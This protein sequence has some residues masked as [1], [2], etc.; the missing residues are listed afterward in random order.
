MDEQ[1]IA[2]KLKANLPQPT[3]QPVA[4]TEPELNTDQATLKVD[5]P[6][7]PMVG[8]KLA[9]IFQ[10]NFEPTDN[11]QTEKMKYVYDEASNIVSSTE[12][13]DVAQ[14]IRSLIS[15]LGAQSTKDPL[16][17]IYQWMKLDANRKKVEQEM[18]LYA[19]WG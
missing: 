5:M 15:M 13:T 11:V 18:K 14:Y 3:S 7:E 16:H 6:L 17:T 19:N 1:V 2:D 10:I 4:P 12:Y 9:D 8:Y